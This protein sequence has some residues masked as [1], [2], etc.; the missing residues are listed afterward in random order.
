[1]Y[2]NYSIAE[3]PTCSTTILC[4]LPFGTCRDE[5][6]EATFEDSKRQPIPAL[7]I[8]VCYTKLS[9]AVVTSWTTVSHFASLFQCHWGIPY[10]V[11]DSVLTGN[12]TQFLSKFIEL[13]FPLLRT[14]HKT[15][16]AYHLQMNKKAECFN[17]TINAHLPHYVAGHHGDWDILAYTYDDHMHRS[18]NLSSFVIIV[19]RHPP[20]PAA[21]DNSTA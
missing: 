17:K 21:L 15:T 20:E 13:V 11:P 12:E 1:M 18:T 9:G 19:S 6:P 8:T 3:T 2:P 7:I 10:G 4:K 14:N 16:V 5:H